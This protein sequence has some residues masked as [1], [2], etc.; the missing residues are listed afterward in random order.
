M[1]DPRRFIEES[2]NY[3]KNILSKQIKKAKNNYP[4]LM[5]PSKIKFSEERLNTVKTSRKYLFLGTWR[6]RLTP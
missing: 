6:L 4:Y 3:Y 2:I 1:L 5:N